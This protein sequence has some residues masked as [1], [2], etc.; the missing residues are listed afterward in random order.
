MG[1]KIVNE[2]SIIILI[3]NDTEMYHTLEYLYVNGRVK[4][5]DVKNQCDVHKLNT[6][7]SKDL[8]DRYFWKRGKHV[9]SMYKINKFGRYIFELATVFRK[10]DED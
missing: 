4:S 8:V 5:I 2:S 9:G 1:K 3:L 7:K 6:L 10:E